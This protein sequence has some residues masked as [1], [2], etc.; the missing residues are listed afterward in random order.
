MFFIEIFVAEIVT[1]VDDTEGE[2][3]RSF[4]AIYFLLL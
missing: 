3:R 1:K 4:Q 2:R